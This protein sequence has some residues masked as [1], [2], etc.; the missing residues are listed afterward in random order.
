MYTFGKCFSG[1]MQSKQMQ[2]TFHPIFSRLSVLQIMPPVSSR[3]TFHFSFSLKICISAVFCWC[4]R[5]IRI[6][7]SKCSMNLLKSMILYSFFIHLNDCFI[8]FQTFILLVL[9]IIR[10]QNINF[11]CLRKHVSNN[12]HE[13]N[14]HLNYYQFDRR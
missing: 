9:D 5:M 7:C 13:G 8:N 14:V 6:Y 3:D 12:T 2:S 10:D 1:N 4:D 11:S